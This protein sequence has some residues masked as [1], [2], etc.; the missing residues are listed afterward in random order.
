MPA[1]DLP[2]FW[3][4]TH[5]EE[6][7]QFLFTEGFDQKRAREF[8]A[9]FLAAW[10][11]DEFEPF[12]QKVHACYSL[13]A[14]YQQVACFNH[15]NANPRPASSGTNQSAF[16]MQEDP[17]GDASDGESAQE[18]APDAVMASKEVQSLAVPLFVPLDQAQHL[19]THH[20]RCCR[21]TAKA[22]LKQWHSGQ[23]SLCLQWPTHKR[24]LLH[25]P[26]HS[27]G[28]EETKQK[29]AGLTML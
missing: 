19:L 1:R 3:D 12:L 6:L 23:S 14:R 22:S 18:G 25:V 10:Q 28:R 20:A 16:V 2:D 7:I 24:A 13:S 8:A 5:D 27:G 17:S 4:T 9:D 29:P 11:G 21:H 15:L 26:R